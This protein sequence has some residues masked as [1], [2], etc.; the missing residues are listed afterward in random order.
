MAAAKKSNSDRILELASKLDHE[1]RAELQKLGVSIPIFDADPKKAGSVSV[2][3]YRCKGC[4]DTALEFVG[5][6]FA[7]ADGS[8]ND[9]PDPQIR[10]SE[11]PIMQ[12][13]QG[14]PIANRSV[15]RCQ[16][17]GTTIHSNHGYPDPRCFI[18]LEE[19]ERNQE[20]LTKRRRSALGAREN[21]RIP[22]SAMV[23]DVD[24]TAVL[25][26]GAS[27]VTSEFVD[28]TELEGEIAAE[29]REALS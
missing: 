2:Y 29:D 16:C 21:T 4:G 1:G 24:P 17:C 20:A 12:S 3:G 22:Q 9:Q 8:E 6:R 10:M 19:H 27:D 5:N 23:Q 26:P 28:S 15:I 7:W 13:R 14:G 18:L 11:Q 25:A